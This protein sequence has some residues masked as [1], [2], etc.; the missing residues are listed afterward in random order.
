L[1]IWEEKSDYLDNKCNARYFAEMFLEPFL[2]KA[3]LAF[4]NLDD[5]FL[6]LI[7]TEIERLENIENQQT[8]FRKPIENNGAVAK[9]VYSGC[10]KSK[11]GNLVLANKMAYGT[12]HV[13]NGNEHF[14]CSNTK[15]WR[16][17]NI[18]NGSEKYYCTN[19]K[20]L[21]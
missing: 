4:P 10:K 13:C 12:C 5:K 2:R 14:S 21:C 9:C 1:E 18:M 8:D 7:R 20:L 19:N 17:M 15:D 11:S 3:E 16:K 6:P